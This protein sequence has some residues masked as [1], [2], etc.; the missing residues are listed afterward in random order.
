M[1][2]QSCQFLYR[3]SFTS[4]PETLPHIFNLVRAAREVNPSPSLCWYTVVRTRA[5]SEGHN[6]M[7]TTQS[8]AGI[9]LS[10]APLRKRAAGHAQRRAFAVQCSK[11]DSDESQLHSS[12]RSAAA[13]AAAALLLVRAADLP[14]I[15][16]ICRLAAGAHRRFNSPP[17]VTCICRLRLRLQPLQ[18]RR[19]IPSSRASSRPHYLRNC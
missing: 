19:W 14:T 5:A 12:A 8:A 16:L 10:G 3:I 18:R 17:N 15:R 7:A 4:I 2:C 11:R 1:T 13:A 9:A 6:L